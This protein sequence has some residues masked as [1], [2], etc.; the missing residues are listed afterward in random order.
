MRF[1]PQYQY[2][3][4]YHATPIS[5]F[6]CK[7]SLTNPT[8][9]PSLPTINDIRNSAPTHIFAV[10]SRDNITPHS[11]RFPTIPPLVIIRFIYSIASWCIYT[12]WD[13]SSCSALRQCTISAVLS[14]ILQPWSLCNAPAGSHAVYYALRCM[15]DMMASALPSMG[16]RTRQLSM[17][18]F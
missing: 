3:Q 16:M 4:R 18:P 15:R 10:V 5:F 8:K 9:P 1:H 11:T 6:L 2:Q 14:L 17:R 13:C 7:Q 12:S